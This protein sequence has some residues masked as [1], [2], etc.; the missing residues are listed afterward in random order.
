[1]AQRRKTEKEFLPRKARKDT[2]KKDKKLIA[3]IILMT[4]FL[5][6]WLALLIPQSWNQRLTIA[7]FCLP[8][9]FCV[10]IM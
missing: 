7:L 1:M 6:F 8:Y 5:V 3:R 2:K 4:E 9:S 10:F